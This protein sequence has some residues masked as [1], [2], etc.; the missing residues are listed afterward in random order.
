MAAADQPFLSIIIPAHN[1]EERLPASLET[2]HAFLQTQPYAAEIIVVENGSND[3]TYEIARA[4]TERI[5]YLRVLKESARGKGLAVRAGMLA[6]RGQ[7]R[8]FADT[9]LSMPI[10]QVNRFIPPALPGMQIAIGSR[11]A[12][13]SVRYEEPQFRHVVGRVFNTIVRVMALP[14]LNDTQA[15]FKCFRGDLA[16]ELFSAQTMTGWSFDVEVLFIARKRGYCIVEVPID[17][18]F[19]PHSKIKVLRDSIRMF[20]D[21]LKI[22]QNAREG[23]YDAPSPV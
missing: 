22:R 17:W 10:E 3:R 16:E 9:D 21:L 4:Y 20:T 19:D 11:E 23:V 15:G 2:I 7:Y 12:P 14:G 1:E 8:F 6:A 18:Y 5:P 13:G